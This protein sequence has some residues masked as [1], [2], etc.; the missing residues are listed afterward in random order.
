M[1]SSILAAEDD[2]AEWSLIRIPLIFLV[3]EEG[4][5]PVMEED[6]EEEE[7]EVEEEEEIYHLPS[8]C[9]CLII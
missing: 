7:E 3:S 4:R 1:R 9:H 8:R 2:A 5:K 6:E